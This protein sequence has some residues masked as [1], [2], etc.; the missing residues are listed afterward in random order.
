MMTKAKVEA[1]DDLSMLAVERAEAD[2][3]LARVAAREAKLNA[4]AAEAERQA[5]TPRTEPI[6]A[7]TV[8][9]ELAGQIVVVARP[10]HDGK[11]MLD[12]DAV[13]SIDGMLNGSLLM[14]RGYFRKHATGMPYVVNPAAVAARGV[15]CGRRR[16]KGGTRGEGEARRGV[17]A[18]VPRERRR[19]PADSGGL[20][21]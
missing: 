1:E 14:D 17:R 16:R 20:E 9:A 6:T 3:A 2:A 5:N 18:E 4:K 7:D 21:A 15:R 8:S 19:R 10:F 11:A 13:A 12:S